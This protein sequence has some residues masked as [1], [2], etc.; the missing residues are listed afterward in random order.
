[1]QEGL[2]NAQKMA[3][4]RQ[5]L[6]DKEAL[7]N[8]YADCA[9]ERD[10]AGAEFGLG[11]TST[12]LQATADFEQ[13][14]T[15]R[16][17]AKLDK[18]KKTRLARLY[19]EYKAGT[20]SK[21]AYEAQ[22]SAIEADYDAKTRA[23]KK[24]AAEKEKMFNI[25]QAIIAGTL[26]VIKASPNVPLMI[27]AGA[28]AAAGVAKIIATPI[29]EFEDGGVVGV[30]KPKPGLVSRVS[31]AAGQVW[32]GVKEYATGRRINPTAGVADVGQRH[33]G[34][35]IR[36]VDGATGQHLGEWEK[37]EAYMIL[38]RDTYANNKHLVD[39]LID[40]SLYRGGAPVKPKPSYSED[41]G[42]FGGSPAAPPTAG[43]RAADSQELV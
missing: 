4:S 42:T 17:L 8:E 9:R 33:S 26:A 18:D 1:M 36:M 34:G 32:R 7:E 37:G 28:K 22:E 35:G 15:D 21:E 3:L 39:E 20:V 27:A 13:L 11:L 43:A 38:S 30:S 6:A 14:A 41:G 5:Y 25:A 10:K 2:N 12:V 29:P 24:E 31:R 16:E 19:A 40:T 23:I